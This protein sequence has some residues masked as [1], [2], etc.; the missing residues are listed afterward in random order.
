[1]HSFQLKISS[2]VKG[3]IRVDLIHVVLGFPGVSEVVILF[4]RF[5]KVIMI[6]GYSTEDFVKVGSTLS[7]LK[8]TQGLYI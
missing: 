7:C 1:M 4:K 8:S 6:L 2:V 3:L 5:Q